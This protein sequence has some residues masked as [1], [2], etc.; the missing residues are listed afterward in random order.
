M[1]GQMVRAEN[2]DEVVML[3]TGMA[4]VTNTNQGRNDE[5][6]ARERREGEDMAWE[7]M[8]AGNEDDQ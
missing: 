6:A 1:P 5:G 2:G 8:D 4:R 7:L 3:P